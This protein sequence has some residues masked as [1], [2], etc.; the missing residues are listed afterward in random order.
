MR[1]GFL[2]LRG[3]QF[4]GPMLHGRLTR[5]Y[6]LIFGAGVGLV[7]LAMLG[8]KPVWRHIKEVRL[9]RFVATA[10][11]ADESGAYDLAAGNLKAALEIHAGH[12]D[13]LRATAQ[14]FTLL[15][16]SM[17][18][19]FW[20]DL[21]SL[22]YA[23][24]EDRL[25]AV[26]LALRCLLP[27]P[28]AKNL[29]RLSAQSPD[30]PV[31]L[32]LYADLRLLEGIKPEAL[33]YASEALN[34]NPRNA[35]AE[36]KLGFLE[37]IQDGPPEVVTAGRAR[38]MQLAIT[39]ATNR[40]TAM[41]ILLVHGRLSRADGLLLQR[42]LKPIAPQDEEAQLVAYALA[43]RLSPERKE[44]ELAALAESLLKPDRLPALTRVAD[45]L[46][47]LKDF[48]AILQLLPED[49]ALKNDQLSR[50]RLGA[51]AGR[52]DWNAMEAML[53]APNLR[54]A[55][56]EAAVFRA[57]VSQSAQRKEEAELRWQLALAACGSVPRHLELLAQHAEATGAKAVAANAWKQMMGDPRL[58]HRAAAQMLRL[59]SETRDLSTLVVALKRLIAITPDDF[60]LQLNLAFSNLMLNTDLDE[61]AKIL[62]TGKGR[63]SDR[64]LF[65][66][67]TAFLEF[68][69]GNTEQALQL[70]STPPIAWE[71][72]PVSWQVVR[73][74]IVGS[75]GQDSWARQLA[76]NL[77]PDRLGAAELKLIG[78]WF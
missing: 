18:L 52:G 70:I 77:H 56:A 53:S 27:E 37:L 74:A 22:G 48:D 34:R 69:R 8:G 78:Q 39:G 33:R 72:S 63:F 9:Q 40:V 12:P 11:K 29:F 55:E 46:G 7:S 32:D 50:I 2:H 65:Q 14:H 64:S 59:G 38:L 5:W 44:P 30:D 51:L 61:A 20:D 4:H 75:A 19:R 58:V 41:H 28:A 31:V 3:V 6:F 67:A 10:I 43:V 16:D 42:F 73:L 15:N 36:L 35:G 54:L 21:D 68:R 1:V 71:T 24:R 57:G 76:R 26:K 47:E 49:R 25:E 60:D 13:A 62:Q 66:V 17:G 45:W 23:T